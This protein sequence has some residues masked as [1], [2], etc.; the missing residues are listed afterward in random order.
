L[1]N[2]VNKD[3]KRVSMCGNLYAGVSRESLVVVWAGIVDVLPAVLGAVSNGGSENARAELPN[4][5]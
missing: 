2:S 5:S 4:M 3:S 1:R